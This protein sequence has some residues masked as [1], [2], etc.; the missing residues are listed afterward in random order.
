MLRRLREAVPHFCMEFDHVLPGKRHSIAKLA[1][2][3]GALRELL[4]ELS[5][6]QLVCV[7]CH[8]A[9][10]AGRRS[11]VL[12]EKRHAVWQRAK[13]AEFKVWL[14]PIK[15]HPCADCGGSFHTEAMDFDHVRSPKLD[16]VANMWR[17]ARITVLAEIAKCDLVCANCHRIRTESRRATR[18]QQKA[19]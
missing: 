16:R 5:L 17:Y 8:R 18:A 2:S 10:T 15:S 13:L 7:C 12:S 1:S 4:R 9:R 6:C 11:A 14:A 19:A 3:G